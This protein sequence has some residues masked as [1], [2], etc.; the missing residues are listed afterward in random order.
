MLPE[1]LS[2]QPKMGRLRALSPAGTRRTGI[3]RATGPLP[4]AV[5]DFDDAVEVVVARD[6]SLDRQIRDR[7]D[8]GT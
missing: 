1:C 4:P 6:L 3:A 2:P 5:F 8:T 7:W